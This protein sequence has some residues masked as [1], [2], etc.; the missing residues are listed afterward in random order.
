M[1]TKIEGVYRWA[2]TALRDAKVILEKQGA[3]F[4]FVVRHPASGA[5]LFEHLGENQDNASAVTNWLLDEI[6]RRER[7]ARIDQA[8]P[9][10]EDEPRPPRNSPAETALRRRYVEVLMSRGITDVDHIV[11]EV[12]DEMGRE[13]A[14]STIRA[15]M[16]EVIAK[17]QKEDEAN[18]PARLARHRRRLYTLAEK[19]ERE[20]GLEPKVWG[21]L[22][23]LEELIAKLEGTIAPRT[24]R[25][26]STKGD[27]FEGW[28]R[29]EK[30]RFAEKGEIPARIR[31]ERTAAAKAANNDSGRTLH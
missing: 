21:P 10:I 28:T 4:R 31:G 15:D 14:Q 7:L 11:E 25:H 24:V 23:K 1:G 3:G 30:R 17:W 8:D 26:E 27:R 22:V 29:E 9:V 12:A 20:A 5:V 18:R 6:A 2:R 13:Y 19:M 16:R